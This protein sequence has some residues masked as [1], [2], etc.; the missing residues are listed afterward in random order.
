MFDRFTST[1]KEVVVEAQE[2]ARAL[3]HDH[4][5]TEH[6]LLGL[7]V[8]E[9]SA[10]AVLAD[11]DLPAAR[12]GVQLLAMLDR[13]RHP[14]RASGTRLAVLLPA[15]AT[16]NTATLAISAPTRANHTVASAL[17]TCRT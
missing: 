16:P 14:P 7:V 9:P 17:S 4:I 13:S 1:A 3:G 12:L 11:L 15:A 8:T 5:G 2:R 6:L 10:A